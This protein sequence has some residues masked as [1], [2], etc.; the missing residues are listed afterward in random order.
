MSV[1]SIMVSLFFITILSCATAGTTPKYD[2]LDYSSD[3]K[4]E[5]EDYLV[6]LDSYTTN[7]KIYHKK[8]YK[9]LIGVA[10]VF[11]KERGIQVSRRS[12]GFYYDKKE[13]SHLLYL[14]VDIIIPSGR[15]SHDLSYEKNSKNIINLFFPEAISILDSCRDVLNEDDIAGM[16]LGIKWQR[17]GKSEVINIWSKK[18][19]VTEYFEKKLTFK[20]LLIRSTFTDTRGKIFRLSF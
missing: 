15:V 4:S 11:I 10:K 17:K 14:G 1:K 19:D 9:Y 7:G 6:S 8:Y 20:E 13:S 16:L 5:L 18:K 2:I 3:Q 12:I